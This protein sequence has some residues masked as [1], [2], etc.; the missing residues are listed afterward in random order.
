MVAH[1]PNL[2]VGGFVA[3]VFSHLHCILSMTSTVQKMTSWRT[4]HSPLPDAFAKHW[5]SPSSSPRSSHP[6]RNRPYKV[7]P[8]RSPTTR[9]QCKEQKTADVD[10]TSL[11]QTCSHRTDFDRTTQRV[12]LASFSSTARHSGVARTL[13]LFDLFFDELSLQELVVTT[14]SGGSTDNCATASVY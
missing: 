11:W 3:R 5:D 8:S 1:R 10:S 6:L 4:L 2:W 13:Q 9:S 7:C 12:W 14:T